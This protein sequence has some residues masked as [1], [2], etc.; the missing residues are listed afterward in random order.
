MILNIAGHNDAPV[1]HKGTNIETPEFLG[2]SKG[3]TRVKIQ[4]LKNKDKNRQI[5]PVGYKGFKIDSA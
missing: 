2:G 5:G 1:G 3:N 4:N